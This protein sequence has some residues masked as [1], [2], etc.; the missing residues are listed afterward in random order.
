[1]KANERRPGAVSLEAAEMAQSLSDKAG[2]PA[3]RSKTRRRAFRHRLV[4]HGGQAGVGILTLIVWEVLSGTV[5]SEFFLS[6]PTLVAKRLFELAGNGQLWTDSRATFIETIVGLVIGA[7]LGVILGLFVAFAKTPGEWIRPYVMMLYSLPRVALAPLFIVWFGIGIHSKVVMVITMVIFPMFYNVYDGIRDM[8][9][10][11]LDMAR[12]MR[13]TRRQLLTWVVLPSITPWLFT[14][15][16]LSIGLGLIGAVIAELVGSTHGL[17]HYIQLSTN[18][19]DTTGVF[20]GLVTVT[21]IAVIME[22]FVALVEKRV[23]RYK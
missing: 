15:L 16:R 17:G 7:F 5:A 21:V 4:I 11:L 2:P 13:A 9:R 19:Y 1:M 23:V 18:L 6:S 20:A 10:H 12:T 22:R 8:D 14:G 3:D